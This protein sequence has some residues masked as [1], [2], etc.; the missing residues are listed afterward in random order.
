MLL[1]VTLIGRPL[2]HLKLHKALAEVLPHIKYISMSEYN[3]LGEILL[4]STSG[5]INKLQFVGGIIDS[6]TLMQ[7][8]PRIE[9]LIFFECELV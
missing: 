9:K 6:Y 5:V 3:F 8:V 7:I 2:K 4:Q 1:V